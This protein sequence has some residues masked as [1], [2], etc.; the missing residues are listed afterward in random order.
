MAIVAEE[1][2]KNRRRSI[3]PRIPERYGQWIAN[4]EM[5]SCPTPQRQ[6]HDVNRDACPQ[7]SWNNLSFRDYPR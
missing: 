3:N 6:P 2:K 1:V 5:F 7:R 4:R